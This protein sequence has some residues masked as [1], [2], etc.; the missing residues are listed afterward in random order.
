MERLKQLIEKLNH[1]V[2][3]GAENEQLME[4]VFEITRSIMEKKTVQTKSPDLSHLTPPKEPLASPVPG[5]ISEEITKVQTDLADKLRQQPIDS[6]RSAMG[7]NEKYIFLQTF[8]KGDAQSFDNMILMLDEIKT[9]DEAR[10]ILEDHIPSTLMNDEQKEVL[11]K[12][13]QLLRRRFFSI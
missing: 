5:N 6:I 11:E 4:T 10:V 1:D 9:Y 3:A 12:F 2:D 7:I 8:F 13:D